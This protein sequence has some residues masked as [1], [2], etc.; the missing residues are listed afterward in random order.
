[1][2]SLKPK[3]AA[4][5]PW[6][7]DAWSSAT[8]A[9]KEQFTMQLLVRR[10]L[11]Q[12]GLGNVA[13][14]G[15]A[16]RIQIGKAFTSDDTMQAIR[17]AITSKS[18]AKTAS[19][20]I[21]KALPRV[22]PGEASAAENPP[23]SLA[24]VDFSELHREGVISLPAAVDAASVCA[25]VKHVRAWILAGKKTARG[26]FKRWSKLSETIGNGC[27]GGYGYYE[28]TAGG[29]L[30]QLVA[31][32]A[33]KLDMTEDDAAKCRFIVLCYGE[34]GENWL[35]ND[36]SDHPFQGLLMLSA[37]GIDFA[38]G[39][40]YI[41]ENPCERSG[42]RS[43]AL[44]AAGDVVLFAANK[45]SAAAGAAAAGAVAR[46]PAASTREFLHGMSTV[47]RGS[48]VVCERWAVGFLQ[49]WSK[50]DA[51]NKKKEDKAKKVAKRAV[52]TGGSTKK[53]KKTH[54]KT[55]TNTLLSMFARKK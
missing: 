50:Q 53:R 46:A 55:Q 33:P 16:D 18:K 51:D 39:E 5:V 9:E 7:K 3:W 22:R 24:A 4:R 43:V 6:L 20:A 49:P 52:A 35:H 28:P 31:A 29:T 11:K 40:L 25:I 19:P 8:D 10:A 17:T 45:L 14:N 21:A 2:A 48:G 23:R 34:D 27:N 36:Q 15:T 32:L 1:M 12:H 42:Y 13:T 38:G 47:T 41:A 37:P 54:A 44:D 26:D 30:R